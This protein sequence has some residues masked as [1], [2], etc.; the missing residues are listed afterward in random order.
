MAPLAPGRFSAM[1]GW[2][3]RGA[4]QSA[5]M[6]AIESVTPPGGNGTTTF[7]ARCGQDCALAT[8]GQTNAAAINHFNAGMSS[9]AGQYNRREKCSAET[10]SS[11]ARARSAR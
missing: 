7:S 10:S 4:S 8:S 5:V 2:P 3:S 1:T 9:S 11:S 6:R